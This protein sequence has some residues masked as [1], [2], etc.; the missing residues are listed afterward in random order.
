MIREDWTFWI[1]LIVFIGNIIDMF[2]RAG[3]CRR[4]YTWDA[5]LSDRMVGIVI[6]IIFGI[7][8]AIAL[9]WL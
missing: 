6:C 3:G 9:G 1:L 8:Y 7:I 2:L 5:D 4:T